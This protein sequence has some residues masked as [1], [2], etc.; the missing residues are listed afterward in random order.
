MS[1]AVFERRHEAGGGWA[2]RIKRSPGLS[3]QYP[4]PDDVSMAA[5][6][7]GS[8]GFPRIDGANLAEMH[9]SS[10]MAHFRVYRRAAR[11]LLGQT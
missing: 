8:A 4:C 10:A 11:Q 2:H 6:S 1:V 9:A 7:P 5:L 3:C